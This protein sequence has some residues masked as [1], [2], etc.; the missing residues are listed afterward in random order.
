MVRSHLLFS[1]RGSSRP[2]VLAWILGGPLLLFTIAA[3]ISTYLFAQG[4]DTATHTQTFQRAL[5]E[6]SNLIAITEE[7]SYHSFFGGQLTKAKRLA[8]IHALFRA[9]KFARVRLLIGQSEPLLGEFSES[10][11]QSTVQA[12]EQLK[13]IND[14]SSDEALVETLKAELEI[15]K[16]NVA[17]QLRTAMQSLVTVEDESSAS[18]VYRALRPHVIRFYDELPEAAPA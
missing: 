15:L 5:A 17:G 3:L 11:L 16:E 10:L 4:L 9:E 1:S 2:S 13:G 8:E 14:P 18:S 6:E 12:E 7:S